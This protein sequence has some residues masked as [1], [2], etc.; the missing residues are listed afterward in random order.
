MRR[1]ICLSQIGCNMGCSFCA[2]GLL[3]KKRNLSC[4]EI[5]AQLIYIQRYLIKD[6]RLNNVVVMGIGEPFDITIMY[7]GFEI[8][9]DPHSLAIGQRHISVSTCGLVPKIKQFADENVGYNLA[10]S[11]HA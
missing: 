1:N 2:S 4:G 5:V 9:N 6:I 11:L 10:I 3:K 8:I 7:E